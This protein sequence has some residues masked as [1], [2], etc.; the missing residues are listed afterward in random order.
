MNGIRK[1]ERMYYEFLQKTNYVET[2]R[3]HEGT[4]NFTDISSF[5]ECE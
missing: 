4:E 5:I 2:S 3:M 1:T